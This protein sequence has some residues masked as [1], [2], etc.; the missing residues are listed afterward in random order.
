MINAAPRMFIGA[1]LLGA[2]LLLGAKAHAHHSSAMYDDHK[3]LT[4]SGKVAKFEWSNPHVYVYLE[5]SVGPD[6]VLWEVECSP[7]SI[8][9]RL[10]WNQDTVHA[11]DTLEVTGS[12]LRDP[13]KKGLLPSKIRHADTVLFDRKGEPARLAKVDESAATTHGRHLDGV[14][15]T[16][17]AIKVEELLDPD[18]LA[19]TPKGKKAAH[20]FDEKTMHPGAQCIPYPSPMFMTTPDLKRITTVGNTLVI[21]G[22]FDG[23]QRSIRL[24]QTSHPDAARSV[25]GD[26]IAHWEGD[27]LIIDTVNFSDHALGN[28]YGVPS[29]AGKHLIERMTLDVD[30]KKLK[31]HFELTD[32]EFLA[33]PVT[34]D[35]EWIFR[36]DLPYTALKCDPENAARY[37]H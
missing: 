15:V 36:P 25:Q 13:S 11:G 18:K 26:S 16:A 8:L 10:G 2:S 9:K 34:A 12:P 1:F 32:P 30:G 7:P 20:N 35:A 28:G 27:T 22:E 37:R 14:W 3:T 19:L 33:K 23:A 29:G 24:D 4:I 21:D 17:L 31:Y 5:Q 6:K